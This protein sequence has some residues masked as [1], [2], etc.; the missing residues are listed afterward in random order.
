M[1]CSPK[2]CA[3]PSCRPGCVELLPPT[4][5]A[6][7]KAQAFQHRVFAAVQGERPHTDEDPGS[8]WRRRHRHAAAW[9]TTL[10]L[11]PWGSA[12]ARRYYRAAARVWKWRH[13]VVGLAHRWRNRWEQHTALAVARRTDVLAPGRPRRW[14]ELIAAFVHDQYHECWHDVATPWT[15]RGEA[16]FLAWLTQRATA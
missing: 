11:E 6:C 16:L 5:S 2:S 15:S 7:A 9:N 14:E 13:H 10:G 1:T 12:P 4:R 3:S 8:F